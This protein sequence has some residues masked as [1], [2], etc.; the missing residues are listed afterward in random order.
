MSKPS[1]LDPPETQDKDRDIDA[2]ERIE[3]ARKAR[4]AAEKQPYR[5]TNADRS[6][7]YRVDSPHSV[8]GSMERPTLSINRRPGARSSKEVLEGVLPRIGCREEIR[9]RVEQ[10]VQYVRSISKDT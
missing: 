9:F 2:A 4:E 3:R 5:G 1:L 7:V 8:G 10:V 6:L